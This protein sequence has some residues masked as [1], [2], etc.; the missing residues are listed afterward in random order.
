MRDDDHDDKDHHGPVVLDALVRQ[1]AALIS[2][3]ARLAAALAKT[4]RL[5][6]FVH[7]PE[8]LDIFLHTDGSTTLPSSATT[9]L[10]TVGPITEQAGLH[11]PTRDTPMIQLTD[12]QQVAVSVSA[13]DKK[14]APASVQSVAFS[15]SD[16]SVAA[17]VADTADQSKAVVVAGLPGTAQIQVS[18]DADL[19][20]GVSLI[21][22][23][24]DVTV[25]GGQAVSLS[26]SA[27]TPVEQA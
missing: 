14:G 17:V 12:T 20:D 5:D 11:G 3:Q 15:S 24:L 25:V 27:G 13:V 2:E 21:S 10:W 19:G 23:T 6:I 22:G 9:L 1:V 16:S 8:R 26:V 4:N 18:A 7:V